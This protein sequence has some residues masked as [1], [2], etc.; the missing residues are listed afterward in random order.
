M[1]QSG[2]LMWIL[3][4]MTLLVMSGFMAQKPEA[5]PSRTEMRRIFFNE[6]EAE[7]GPLFPVIFNLAAHARITTNATCGLDRP[8]VYCKLVEHVLMKPPQCGICDANSSDP[9]KRHPIEDAIDGSPRWW[10]SPSVANGNRYEYVTV[11]IDMRQH[12]Q[13]AY[14]I[15]KAANSPRPAAWELARSQDGI[16]YHPWMFFARTESECM[17]LFGMTG[18]MGRAKF[19]TDD[20]VVCSTDYGR[21]HPLEDGEIHASL[22]ND[23]PGVDGPSKELIDWTTARYVR[24]RLMKLH[25]LTADLIPGIPAHRLLDSSETRRYFYSIKDISIGGQ[26]ICFGHARDCPTDVE[27]IARCQC[28]HNTC[29]ESCERCCPLFNQ[30]PWKAGTIAVPSAC[31]GCQCHGHADECRYDQEIANS[32]L[33][34]SITGKYEG[35]GVC[36]NCQHNTTGTNC[37]HCVDG[38]FR[39]LGVDKFNPIGCLQ[40]ECQD[41]GTTGQCIADEE[42][43]V[44]ELQPGDCVCLEGFGG[45]KCDHCAPGYRNYPDCEPCPCNYAGS[46]NG[47]ACEGDC[48]CKDNVEG[49]RCDVCREGF[50][51]LDANN[52]QGCTPCFCFGVTDKCEGVGWNVSKVVT[53]DEWILTDSTGSR[54]LYPS[55]LNG[56]PVVAA[57]DAYEMDVFYWLAP[58][59]YRGN[60]LTSYGGK[61]DY[62]ITFIKGRGDLTGSYTADVDVIL[63]GNGVRIGK[64]ERFFRESTP[65]HSSAT[66]HEHGWHHVTLNGIFGE[67]VSKEQFMTLLANVEKLMIRGT[68]HTRQL[69]SRLLHV[70]MSVADPKQHETTKMQS[71]ERCDCPSGYEG[72][73]CETCTSGHRRVNQTMYNGICVPCHCYAHATTCDPYDGECRDCL[74][75]TTGFFCDHCAAGYYG[76]AQSGDPNSCKPCGCPLMTATNNFSPT[77]VAGNTL[78]L[79]G[80]YVCTDCPVGYNG[81]KCEMCSDGYFGNPLV[82]GNFCQ[83]CVCSGNVDLAAVGNCERLT[84]KCLKCVGNTEG[85]SC[86]RCKKGFYGNALRHDCQACDCSPFG[87][88]HSDCNRQNGQCVCKPG[89]EGKKC[90]RCASGFGQI[91]EGCLPCDCDPVGALSDQCDPSSGQCECLD[92]V[93]GLHCRRCQEGFYGFSEVGCTSC[94][95]EALGS[96]NQTCN[97]ETG[98][99][100]CKA[101]IEERNCV[102]CQPLFWGITSGKGCESCGCNTT[103]AMSA[104]CDP[105]SGRCTCKPGV[106]GRTCSECEVGYY[107]LSHRGCTKCPVCRIPGQVCDRHT[108]ECICPTLTIGER[109]ERCAPNSHDYHPLLGCKVCNCSAVGSSG[110]SCD[111]VTGQCQCRPSF[112]SRQCDQCHFG[113]YSFPQCKKCGCDLKGSSME[114]CK[115]GKCGCDQGGSGQCV[116]KKNVEG[117]EC[118]RC[119]AKTFTL[120]QHNPDGCTACFCSGKSDRCWQAP[121]IWKA[122]THPGNR[123]DFT[124]IPPQVGRGRHHGQVHYLNR[125]L[126]MDTLSFDVSH[127]ELPKKAYETPFYWNLPGQFLGDR[128]ISY[129]GKL[130]FQLDGEYP[131]EIH[132]GRGF[133]AFPLALLQGNN[134]II[135][136]YKPHRTNGHGVY[137]IHFHESQW[138]NRQSPQFPVSRDLLMVALQNVQHLLVRGNAHPMPIHLQI[139]QIEMEVAGRPSERGTGSGRSALGVEFCDCPAGYNGSSCQNAATGYYR[140]HAPDALDHIDHFKLLGESVPCDCHNHSKECDADSGRCMN[141]LHQ[142]EG[143][144]CQRCEK[145]YYGEAHKGQRDGCKRCACPSVDHNYSE[146]CSVVRHDDAVDF[147]CDRCRHGFIGEKCESCEKGY[148]G[149]PRRGVPCVPC[150]CNTWGSANNLCDVLTGQCQCRGGLQGRDCSKCQVGHVITSN[151]CVNCMN[152]KCIKTLV[153][154]FSEM[155]RGLEY[156]NMS[157]LHLAPLKR[158][159]RLQEKYDHISVVVAGAIGESTF[160]MDSIFPAME[161]GFDFDREIRRVMLM[162]NKSATEAIALKDSGLTAQWNVKTTCSDVPTLDHKIKQLAETLRAYVGSESSQGSL[163]VQLILTEAEA[164]LS[165][166]LNKKKLFSNTSAVAE[167]SSITATLSE[168][169]ALEGGGELV[170][171][172]RTRYQQLRKK[173]T[174]IQQYLENDIAMALR[175]TRPLTI[176]AAEKLTELQQ[177]I[178][179][180]KEMAGNTTILLEKS[181]SLLYNST[182]AKQNA[183]K[184]FEEAQMT[185]KG[186]QEALAVLQNTSGI[187]EDLNPEYREK[188][189]QP[190]LDHSRELSE[191]AD[192]LAELFDSAKAE[193]KDPMIAARVYDKIVDQVNEAENITTKVTSTVDG[194]FLVVFPETD[195]PLGVRAGE[196]LNKSAELEETSKQLLE[197]DVFSLQEQLDEE[198]G[199]LDGVNATNQRTGVELDSIAARLEL[200]PFDLTERINDIQENITEV[201]RTASD[202]LVIVDRISDSIAADVKP[203]FDGIKG[204]DKST[205][206][207]AER[208]VQESRRDIGNLDRS[209]ADLETTSKSLDELHRSMAKKIQNLR[210]VILKAKQAAS[211]LQVSLSPDKHGVCRRSFEPPIIPSSA[212][213]ITLTYSTSAPEKS[214]LLMYIGNPRSYAL[215]RDFM[216]VEVVNGLVRFI[217]NVGE[218]TKVITHP[219]A[220]LPNEPMYMQQNTWYKIEISRV[221][222]TAQLSVEPMTG[223]ALGFEPLYINGSSDAGFSRMDLNRSSEMFVGGL[224]NSI[225]IPEIQSRGFF[226]CLGQVAIDGQS[227]GLWNYKTN[228][229]CA[230]CAA[231]VAETGDGTSFRF[232]GNGFASAPQIKRYNNKRYTIALTFRTFDENALLFLC[233]NDKEPMG[234]FISLEL[235]D[236]KVVFQFYLG[237]Q[238]HLLVMTNRRFNSGNFVNVRAERSDFFADLRVEDDHIKA[239]LPPNKPDGLELAMKDMYFG[240]VPP[241]FAFQSKYNITYKPFIGCLKD[242]QV[243]VT[244]VDLLSKTVYHVDIE[245][246]CKK[247]AIRDVSFSNSNGYLRLPGR[248]LPQNASISFSFATAQA[249]GLLIASISKDYK[250]DQNYWTASLQAGRLVLVFNGGSVAT[251]IQVDKYYDDRVL[252]TVSL[253]KRKKKIEVR[254]DDM[255]VQEEKLT[256]GSGNITADIMYIGGAPTDVDLSAIA[257]SARSFVGCFTGLIING[258]LV[259]FEQ[260][261]AFDKAAVGRCE[262]ESPP[263]TLEPASELL[264]QALALSR[265]ARSCVP[266]PKLIKAPP[267]WNAVNFAGTE[268]SRV[269]IFPPRKDTKLFNLT[270]SFRTLGMNGLLFYTDNPSGEEVLMMSLRKGSLVLTVVDEQPQEIFSSEKVSDGQWHTVRL[271]KKSRRAVL[272][273]DGGADDYLKLSKRFV[274][275]LPFYVA[276]TSDAVKLP[277]GMERVGFRGCIANVTLNE[278]RIDLLAENSVQG[279]GSCHMNIESAAYFEGNGYAIQSEGFVPNGKIQIEMEI[280]T[281]SLSGELILLY[282]PV[283]RSYVQL[284]HVDGQLV[285]NIST[286]AASFHVTKALSSRHHLCDGLWHRVKVLYVSNVMMLDVDDQKEEVAYAVESTLAL[287]EKVPLY[288]GGRPPSIPAHFV[289]KVPNFA[290]CIRGVVVNGMA[291][292]FDAVAALHNVLLD[293]CPIAG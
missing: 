201:S 161:L 90:D 133:S 111:V 192:M 194:V 137:E 76:D 278:R 57:D 61:L 31:E 267:S 95:C 106:T 205:L 119:K 34:V 284:K 114:S 263:P 87:S 210:D 135:L 172:V 286:G 212:N 279:V 230:G 191:K 145:G 124:Y 147:V 142:T 203:Q 25:T 176:E 127:V 249:D 252:H 72:L 269:E 48:E 242:I 148:Y 282:D 164:I 122:I 177:M 103:G 120:D 170:S 140:K 204:V 33:S 153:D 112:T 235:R 18:T 254:V 75:N 56:T 250:S 293:S 47:E 260:L 115:D 213:T 209:V 108:G 200:L 256:T 211:T 125:T 223:G 277:A 35:G 38:F 66:L 82:P 251:K 151:G 253:R 288:V 144:R 73:S 229:G 266:F 156:V 70:A 132:R 272:Q 15:I 155:D 232:N 86:E 221:K 259:G 165:D 17:E 173:I 246:G 109:C 159:T 287:P 217:W 196:V 255:E 43:M 39:P 237:G 281:N 169:E 11:I 206:D 81:A 136:D 139:S 243:D 128:I 239:S 64:G 49:A 110:E 3:L 78:S 183:T 100:F 117:R 2:C 42:S 195:S 193:A 89:Y 80:D 88:E 30:K 8:E 222:H 227:I 154:E 24:L 264:P 1:E 52:P 273:V 74:H 180:V 14:I 291:I 185:L 36:V 181:Q 69:E 40:C 7:H 93:F 275:S 238:N 234:D 258:V 274:V 131:P 175:S 166:I 94:D 32:R 16:T 58:K 289:P 19:T 10:Q 285:F 54:I 270:M 241:G 190:A 178:K 143:E 107:G 29:G 21:I 53:L 116:C 123:I 247:R 121:Y 240:G 37:E 292:S 290:G 13:V 167:L 20:Q 27:G 12:Y 224:P 171:A 77:C 130:R 92:G 68:Y 71:V 28:A 257:A 265:H 202:A 158:M 225:D 226:G 113:F 198:T 208:L 150:Q 26:C 214:S 65:H 51:N 45:P 99:C 160:F 187:L 245:Q 184:A 231:G 162:A 179:T 118:N 22:I 104:S 186:F 84:G 218:D 141:C 6:E 129:N 262:F 244:T 126:A 199:R 228:E 55:Y 146:S 101:N 280:R 236:G 59:P 163:N 168:I 276:G 152:D 233:A 174:E 188:Y 105:M 197:E 62:S 261:Q 67:F 96:V 157:G 271:E 182:R 79:L 219:K 220:L 41:F 97:Q 138:H 248:T 207:Q 83:P 134:R 189:F 46:K 60:R 149:N 102:K 85:F 5:L 23:R 63:E 216:A 215:D 9:A 44:G 50:F 283:K 91:S 98:Q 4:G 268:D